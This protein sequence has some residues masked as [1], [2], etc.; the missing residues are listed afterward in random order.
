MYEMRNMITLTS[1]Q[2]ISCD[3]N[4]ASSLYSVMKVYEDIPK[5]SLST[6]FVCCFQWSYSRPGSEIKG[7]TWGLR[8]S[9]L[10]SGRFPV[11]EASLAPII[12]CSTACCS[13]LPARLDPLA[14]HLPPP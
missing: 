14:P 4:D 13:T 6:W 8:S 7:R 3:K 10:P 1:L 9:G 12:F 5:I 2:M 11:S